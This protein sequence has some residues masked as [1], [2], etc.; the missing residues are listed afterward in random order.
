MLLIL[1]RYICSHGEAELRGG[2]GDDVWRE[3]AN[4]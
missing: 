1:G 2:G 3:G 4:C